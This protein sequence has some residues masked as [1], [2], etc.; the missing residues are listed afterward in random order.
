[1]EKKLLVSIS[2]L[3]AAGFAAS[4][5]A[6][7]IQGRNYADEVVSHTKYVQR[8]GQSGCSG[9]IP[10]DSNSPAT[11]WWLLG[12][13]DCD[14]DG[15]MY[16]FTHDAN[17]VITDNDY[18]AGWK[19]ASPLTA[20][21]EFVLKFNTPLEDYNDCD[22]FFIR[23]YCG[24]MGK[25]SVWASGDGNDFTFIGEIVGEYDE[26]PGT[27][28]RLYDT[29]FDFD[30]KI[31][32]DVHYIKLFREVTAPDSGFFVDCIG[33]AKVMEPVDREQVKLYGWT[34]QA[35]INGDC[36]INFKDFAQMVNDWQLC[37]NPESQDCNYELFD[38]P[39]KVPSCCYGVWQSGFG[40]A[41]DINRDCR[42]DV[43]DL[44]MLA[45]DWLVSNSLVD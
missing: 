9:G 10:I 19:S 2:F 35:D 37:N 21:Q 11:T 17:G 23:L 28:G 45:E 38:D 39:N 6:R 18:V 42:V 40:I 41:S 15:D 4:S 32:G 36:D 12:K 7:Y 34:M 13:E 5:Q 24:G 26:I 16:A 20:N 31:C 3:L 44:K 25:G 1:M 30:D 14:V 33:S 8:F 29:Y 43:N 22:D 27:P